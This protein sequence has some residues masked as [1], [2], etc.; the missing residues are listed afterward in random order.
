MPSGVGSSVLY[1][2]L[3]GGMPDDGIPALGG[4]VGA[5][6]GVCS[7]GTLGR[8]GAMFLGGSAPPFPA[9]APDGPF[10][11]AA[12]PDGAFPIAAAPDGAF[13][14]AAAPDGAFPIAATS[15]PGATP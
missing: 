4:P 8:M 15:A 5:P 7:G 9:A 10:P 1:A 11:I 14:I 6:P 12:A 3:P 13:P 2:M